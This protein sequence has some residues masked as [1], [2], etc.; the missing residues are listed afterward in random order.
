MMELK[1]SDLLASPLDFEKHLSKSRT[2]SKVFLILHLLN[3]ENKT[4]IKC[5]ELSR[6]LMCVMP[7]SYQILEVFAQQGI[8][9]KK[10]LDGKTKVYLFT[11]NLNDKYLLDIAK[12]TIGVADEIHS[13]V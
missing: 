3:N 4:G 10:A 13:K 12:K 5:K 8:L 7:Y 2:Y 11:E 1:L 9:T 6:M